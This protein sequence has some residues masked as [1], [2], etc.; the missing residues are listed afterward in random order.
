MKP[1]ANLPRLSRQT[2]SLLGQ[3]REFP[4]KFGQFVF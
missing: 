3:L 2:F 1:I 4:F